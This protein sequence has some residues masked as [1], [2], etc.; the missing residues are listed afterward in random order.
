MK[1]LVDVHFTSLGQRQT[2][3]RMQKLL[4]LPEKV[5]TPGWR[6]TQAKD[7]PRVAELLR[8]Y[9]SKFKV[10]A[11]FS[12]EEVAHWF[13]P[14]PGVVSSFVVDSGAAV[15]DFGS[16]YRLDSSILN[17]AKHPTLFAAY[18]FYN[19]PGSLSVQKLL[20][21]L[22]VSAAA[23]GCDVFNVLDLME[24]RPVFENLRFGIGDGNLHF[25]MYN[26]SVGLE[27]KPEEIGLVLM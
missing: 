22:L 2:L 21:N 27:L 9:L 13:L 17:N 15:T 11:E 14:R 6:P 25:Y 24:N 10:R 5:D 7:V 8:G 12:E 26:F 23:E 4:A 20:H 18:S 3:Q 1:K 19:V 16:Y